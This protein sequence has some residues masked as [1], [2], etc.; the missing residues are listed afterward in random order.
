MVIGVTGG[1]GSGKTSVCRLFEALG[2]LV[3][4]ADRTGREVVEDPEVLRALIAAFGEDIV[5]DGRLDRRRL[6][7]RA[8]ADPASSERLN[9]IVWPPLVR[10]LRADAEAALRER[11][12]RPVVID[13]A[14][15]VEWGDLS[16]LDAL[17]VV[18]ADEQ[19]RKA[20]MMAR[21]GLSGEEVEARMRAQLPEEEKARRAD[22]VIVND[23]TEEDLRARA[24]EVWERLTAKQARRNAEK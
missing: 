15:L 14:L 19:A 13:A 11:P 7:Q 4:E 3:I 12:D 18:T 23:G 20:R 8:F 10:K 1:L 5:E 16:W 2:A 24:S 21:M 22:Y 17:V 6:G 9:R